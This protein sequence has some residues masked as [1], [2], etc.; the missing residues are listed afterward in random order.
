MNIN[1]QRQRLLTSM[2]LAT[3]LLLGVIIALELRIAGDDPLQSMATQQVQPE[4][5]T[6]VL[7]QST[8]RLAPIAHYDEILARPLFTE[9]RRPP[10]REPDTAPEPVKVET[11]PPGFTL[12]GIVIATDASKALLLSRRSRELIQGVVGDSVEGWRIKDIQPDRITVV[13]GTESVD[14]ELERAPGTPASARSP[15]RVPFRQQHTPQ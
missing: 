13:R 12:L 4:E 5:N 15:A 1:R 2:L 7:P 9:E 8:F 14:I 6:L 3:N 10:E 11:V